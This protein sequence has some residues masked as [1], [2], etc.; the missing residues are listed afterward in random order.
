MLNKNIVKVAVTL[1]VGFS[2]TACGQ[3]ETPN[4]ASGIIAAEKSVDTSKKIVSSKWSEFQQGFNDKKTVGSTVYNARVTMAGGTTTA[5]AKSSLGDRINLKKWQ[6]FQAAFTQRAE[7]Y[8]AN[9]SK[10]FK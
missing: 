2:V 5:R 4:S 1:I 9:I 10:S 8:V 6:E 3:S 7:Y